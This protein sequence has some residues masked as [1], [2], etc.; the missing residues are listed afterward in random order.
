LRSLRYFWEMVGKMGGGGGGADNA[1]ELGAVVVVVL[2][3]PLARCSLE[4]AIQLE[5]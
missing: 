4:G 1:E 5:S 3:E 2:A